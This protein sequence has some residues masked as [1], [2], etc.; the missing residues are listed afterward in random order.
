MSP[1]C[2]G[3][4]STVLRMITNNSQNESL[5]GISRKR[6]FVFASTKM[7][8]RTFKTNLGVVKRTKMKRSR[9]TTGSS[10]SFQANTILKKQTCL[11]LRRQQIQRSR[12]ECFRMSP[13]TKSTFTITSSSPMFAP[14]W[15]LPMR[16]VRSASPFQ[17]QTRAFKLGR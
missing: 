13:T 8:W 12:K 5:R 1:H 17:L 9:L 7:K 14:Q 3:I 10:K 15:T 2:N 16:I 4:L 11:L 6:M